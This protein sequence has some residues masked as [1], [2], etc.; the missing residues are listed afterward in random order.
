MEI[1]LSEMETD[2]LAFV[3]LLSRPTKRLALVDRHMEEDILCS[4]R[5]NMNF[6]AEIFS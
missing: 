5:N 4:K 6:F 3:R 1:G 2:K